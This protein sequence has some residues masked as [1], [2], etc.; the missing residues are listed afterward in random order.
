VLKNHAGVLI[1]LPP[2]LATSRDNAGVLII[3]KKFTTLSYDKPIP[4]QTYGYNLKLTRG[5]RSYDLQIIFG[6]FNSKMIIL[7]HGKIP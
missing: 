2:R 3:L 1:H 6:I 7:V 5:S 4:Q